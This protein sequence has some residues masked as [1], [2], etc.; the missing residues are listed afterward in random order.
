MKTTL[1]IPDNKLELYETAK[2]E[3]GDSVSATF[4]QCIERELAEKRLRIEQIIV[5]IQDATT[6][7][8]EKKAFRGRWILGD[9]DEGELHVWD[10]EKT[11]IRGGAHYSVAVT[12]KNAIAV[13]D[14]GT[15][16]GYW[17]HYAVFSGGF[18]EFRDSCDS[19]SCARFPGSLINAVAAELDVNHIEHLDI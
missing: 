9:A 2:K 1:Y 15:E 10:E 5:E 6:E 14:R 4:L 17:D 11:G 3:L 16:D 8:I 13:F 18:D 19:D 12:A 7:R